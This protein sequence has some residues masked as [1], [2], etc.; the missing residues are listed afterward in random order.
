MFA[1]QIQKYRDWSQRLC[2]IKEAS[3][4]IRL[5]HICVAC[6]RGCD[7][8]GCIFKIA[9]VLLRSSKSRSAS[10]S[11]SRS[12]SVSDRSDRSAGEKKDEKDA[13]VNG[14]ADKD[15]DKADEAAPMDDDK[16]DSPAAANGADHKAE[17]DD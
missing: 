15:D 13:D 9:L 7:A 17:E 16:G 1:A 12:K 14:A 3:C 11:R 6:C 2:S 4:Q 8:R 10:K 5:C